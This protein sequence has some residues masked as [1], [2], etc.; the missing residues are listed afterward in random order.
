[1]GEGGG[2]MNI[3]E[4]LEVFKEKIIKYF[5]KHDCLVA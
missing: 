2:G 1:M 4:I 5:Y 3:N